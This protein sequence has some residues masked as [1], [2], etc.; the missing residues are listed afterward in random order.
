MKC[1]CIYRLTEIVKIRNGQVVPAVC[2][3]TNCLLNP[4][5]AELSYFENLSFGRKNLV[6]F[7]K[8][9][10]LPPSKW[11]SLFFKNKHSISLI[12][13]R[14]EPSLDG[15]IYILSRELEGLLF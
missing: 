14:P 7:K 4:C 12:K 8:F 1:N 9:P 2:E 5:R 13:H 3:K 6:P 11:I 15:S 10:F